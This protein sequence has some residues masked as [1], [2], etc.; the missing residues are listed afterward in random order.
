MFLSSTVPETNVDEVA[1]TAAL[2]ICE[3]LLPEKEIVGILKDASETH[4]NAE[5]SANDALHATVADLID[6]IISCGTRRPAAVAS[7]GPAEVS[8][9]RR[10]TAPF[11][12]ARH[13]DQFLW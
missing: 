8:P 1:G 9:Y 3:P 11:E 12:K 7:T 13:N 5:K 4:R 10:K 2:A 6:H